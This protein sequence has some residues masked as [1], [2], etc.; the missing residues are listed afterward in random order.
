M[1]SFS[2]IKIETVKAAVQDQ[3]AIQMPTSVNGTMA[4]FK[5]A[6]VVAFTLQQDVDV[7][8]SRNMSWIVGN[9]E[10]YCKRQRAAGPPLQQLWH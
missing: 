7:N 3:V 6:I 1:I 9:R 4:L 2:Q 10:S 5:A 8:I